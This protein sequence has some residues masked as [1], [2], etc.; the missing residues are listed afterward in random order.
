MDSGRFHGRNISLINSGLPSKLRARLAG[1][2]TP[3][4]ADSAYRPGIPV[5]DR[6]REQALSLTHKRRALVPWLTMS[7]APRH[8][9]SI[10]SRLRNLL[11]HQD[12][13]REGC[14]FTVSPTDDL[15]RLMPWRADRLRTIDCRIPQTGTPNQDRLILRALRCAANWSRSFETSTAP[16]S[17]ADPVVLAHGRTEP[18]ACH[19][20]HAR[21][22]TT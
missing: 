16:V 8:S 9:H 5:P 6:P 2:V 19:S 15:R 10:V 12:F 21:V 14:D 1:T 11:L 7:R 17:N 3:A 20:S 13:S 22:V 4:T 18:S